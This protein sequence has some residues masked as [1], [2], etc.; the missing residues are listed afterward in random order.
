MKCDAV[1]LEKGRE[2]GRERKS[3][4]QTKEMAKEKREAGEKAAAG[5]SRGEKPTKKSRREMQTKEG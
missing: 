4:A 1:R 5:C 3:D 2:S